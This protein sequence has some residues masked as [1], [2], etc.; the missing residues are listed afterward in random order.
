MKQRLIELVTA[1]GKEHALDV[2]LLRTEA[3]NRAGQI[4]PACAVNAVSEIIRV[5]TAIAWVSAQLSRYCAIAGCDRTACNQ[6]QCGAPLCEHHV[7]D[8]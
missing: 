2:A 6:G 4:D 7:E 8:S 1:L 5:E 3:I